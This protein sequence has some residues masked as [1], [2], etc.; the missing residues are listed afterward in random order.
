MGLEGPWGRRAGAWRE[1]GAGG[2]YQEAVVL[3]VGG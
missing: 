3:G 1:G 2:S